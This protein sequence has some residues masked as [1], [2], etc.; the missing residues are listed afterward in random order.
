MNRVIAVAV[1]VLSFVTTLSACGSDT[2]N[3]PTILVNLR[4]PR[5]MVDGINPEDLNQVTLL[6][7]SAQPYPA[8]NFTV[9]DTPEPKTLWYETVADLPAGRYTANPLGAVFLQNKKKST[10][11]R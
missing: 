5:V 9:L 8:K 3:V 2:A 4:G 1:A 7:A 6:V 10:P 11:T